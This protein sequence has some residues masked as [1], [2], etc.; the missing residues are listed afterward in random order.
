MKKEVVKFE[1]VKAINLKH[2]E[3][4]FT[5]FGI[6]NFMAANKDDKAVKELIHGLFPNERVKSANDLKKLLTIEFILSKIGD[7]KFESKVINHKKVPQTDKPRK[8]F[9]TFEISRILRKVAN[10]MANK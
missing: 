2:K 6:I 9:S 4:S 7:Y 10:E 3:E 5:I 8:Y 1:T